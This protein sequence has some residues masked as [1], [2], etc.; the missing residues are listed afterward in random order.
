[1][2]PMLSI[3]W[4]ALQGYTSP[5][6]PMLNKVT[7]APHT[8][9]LLR[10]LRSEK[11]SSILVL[12][13]CFLAVFQALLRAVMRFSGETT[14][15]G[16][17]SDLPIIFTVLKSM[18]AT[19]SLLVK[20]TIS[21]VSCMLGCIRVIPIEVFTSASTRFFMPLMAFWNVSGPLM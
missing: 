1:M 13:P 17:S 8:S 14:K 2:F 20:W 18:D 5:L 19:P 16:F 3:P 10:S 7:P 12:T 21:S 9:F 6:A 15:S 11:I 4:N